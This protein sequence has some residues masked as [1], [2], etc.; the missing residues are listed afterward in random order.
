MGRRQY[1]IYIYIYIYIFFFSTCL[2]AHLFTFL[3][4]ILLKSEFLTYLPFLIN[5]LLFT[6][7]FFLVLVLVIK[8]N[9]DLFLTYM[10]ASG[11]R[12]I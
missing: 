9:I 7:F 12:I 11:K 2:L 5:I 4:N 1:Y 10:A 3:I 6:V 8:I